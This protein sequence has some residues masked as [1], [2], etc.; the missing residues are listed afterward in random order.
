MVGS[1]TMGNDFKSNIRS[2]FRGL[3]E[4]KDFFDITL[5]CNNEQLEAHKVILSACSPFFRTVLWHNRH[6]HPLL[7]LK[8]VKYADLVSILN[9]LYHGKV[10]VAEELLHSFLA[11]CED[12]KVK[13]LTQGPGS[14]SENVPTP[15]QEPLPKP[16]IQNLPEAAAPIKQEV[17]NI[18][19]LES[20]VKLETAPIEPEPNQYIWQHQDGVVDPNM[21]YIEEFG[22]NEA[23]EEDLNDNSMV[24]PN[25]SGA[26][27]NNGPNLTLLKKYSQKDPLTG[28]FV[29]QKCGKESKAKY[30]IIR[31][32]EAIHFAGQFI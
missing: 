30:N 14:S 20:K 16:R 5:A 28:N 12:L 19:E 13:G 29:C 10:N 4:D 15:R 25:M 26:D 2:A 24:D 3:R 9:F 31:H 1:I 32:I 18:Q 21:E 7:Y 23:Y 6:K 17:N 22:D 27:G 11:V 8:G